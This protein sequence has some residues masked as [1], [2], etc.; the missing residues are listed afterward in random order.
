MSAH[1][2]FGQALGGEEVVVSGEEARHAVRVLRIRPGERITVSDGRGEVAVACVVSA[3]R[4]LVARVE[5]RRT[6]PPARPRLVVWAAIPKAGK[7]DLVAA[8]LTEIGA[9]ALVPFAARRSVARWD[10]VKAA[11]RTAH[12]RAIARE[13]SRQSRR[14]W[15]M[16]VSE[17]R[18]LGETG[19]PCIVLHEEASRRLSDGLP[20]EPPA[21]LSLVVGPEGGLDAE[22]V[23][24]L[25]S[26]GAGVVGLGPQILRTETAGLVAATIVLARYGLLG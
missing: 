3:G 14:A 9:A 11:A 26:A 24:A 8:K 2:F 5:E 1:H 16:E 19:R 25:A 21:E 4:D 10:P 23:A 6:V 13:A 22:E 15:I 20:P 12:L 7:L 17:V 18:A